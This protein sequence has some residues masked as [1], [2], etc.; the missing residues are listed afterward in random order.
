MIISEFLSEK[1]KNQFMVKFSM[2][3]N[4]RDFGMYTDQ[5]VTLQFFCHGL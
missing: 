3:L 1:K 4:S 5:F 2:Y